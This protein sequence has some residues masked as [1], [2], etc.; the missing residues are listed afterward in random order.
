MACDGN[1]G[2]VFPRIWT[3]AMYSNAQDAFQHAQLMWDQQSQGV[4]M[5]I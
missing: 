3:W 2:D 4:Y 5:A 1:S